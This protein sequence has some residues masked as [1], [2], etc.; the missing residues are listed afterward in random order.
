MGKALAGSPFLDDDIAIYTC[1]Q[2][3]TSGAGLEG[4]YLS[5]ERAND[6]PNVETTTTTSNNQ[7]RPVYVR[8]R[9]HKVDGMLNVS[10][11]RR[12][13][14]SVRHPSIFTWELIDSRIAI[15]TNS[16]NKM[17]KGPENSFDARIPHWKR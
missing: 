9:A 5:S 3:K 1:N 6:V 15:L 16:N 12:V 7:D 11:E 17:I 13:R 10:L 2:F 8:F 14:V 4:K